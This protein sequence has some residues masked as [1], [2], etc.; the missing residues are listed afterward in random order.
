MFVMFCARKQSVTKSLHQQQIV[1]YIVYQ[2]FVYSM[3]AEEIAANS[4]KI[5]AVWIGTQYVYIP[6][7]DKHLDYR[8]GKTLQNPRPT[9]GT[10]KMAR[11]RA[12][13]GP[14]NTFSIG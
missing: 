7:G 6:G 1:V 8:S 9:D 3:D 4:F 13:I 2:F 11:S 14:K 5:P 12:S 10:A